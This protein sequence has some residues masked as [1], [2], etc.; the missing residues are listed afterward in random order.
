MEKRLKEMMDAAVHFGH[1]T[2][3]WNPKIAPYLHGEKSGVHVFNLEKTVECLD[4]ATEFLRQ[5]A[6]EGKEILFVSTKPQTLEIIPGE[7]GKVAM[8]YVVHKWLGGLL[9]NFQ[10]IKARIRFLKKTKQMFATGEVERYTKKEQ[11]KLRKELAK[12]QMALGG[13][14]DMKGVPQVMFIVDVM[15]D[16]TALLEAKKLNIPVVAICD[17]NANPQ[18]VDFPIPAND[19]A[20]KSLKYI[21]GEVFSAVDKGKK[22]APAKKIVEKK[23]DKAPAKKEEKKSEK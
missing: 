21:L 11:M 7:C 22:S 16:H 6:A 15:R 13:V 1:K 14:E 12:L 17:T 10:T 3:R 19:D 18:E 5:S 4:K 23:E 9:T 8:P 20:V 2:S